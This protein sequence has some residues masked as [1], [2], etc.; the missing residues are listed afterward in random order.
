M[1]EEPIAFLRAVDR[2]AARTVSRGG[3]AEAHK[4][5]VRFDRRELAQILR[6]YGR[7]VAAGE[8]RDYAIDFLSDRAVF[9]AFR[10]ASETPFYTIEK[11]PEFRSR[12]GE[13]AVFAGSGHLL[14][15]ARELAHVLRIFDRKLIRALEEA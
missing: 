3:A 4:S 7:M 15:R 6:V 2:P 12:Q 13:Y 11:H 1:A 9:S 5:E 8:W 14:K 10:H